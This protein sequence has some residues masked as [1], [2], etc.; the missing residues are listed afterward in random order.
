MPR[1]NNYHEQKV[2]VVAAIRKIE[3][4][5]SYV[6]ERGAIFRGRNIDT[7]IV[8]IFLLI[9]DVLKEILHAF[10]RGLYSVLHCILNNVLS[11]Q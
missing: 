5:V 3:H 7:N 8:I 11:M 9:C 2:P 1:Q 6:P 10:V 4:G